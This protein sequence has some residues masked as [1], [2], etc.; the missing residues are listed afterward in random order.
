MQSYLASGLYDLISPDGYISE[1]KKINSA[2]AIATV[3]IKNISPAYKGFCLDVRQIS[4]NLKSTLAQLGLN[5]IG[6]EYLL[7]EKMR[8]AEVKVLLTAYGALAELLLDNLSIGSYIGKLFAADDRR[9]VRDPDYLLR[10][11]N[12]NDRFGRPLLYL[13]DPLNSDNLLLEKKDDH[14]VAFLTLLNGT[15]TYETQTEGFIPTLGK[16]LQGTHF[17]L[18][19][20]LQL[21]QKWNP[22]YLKTAH[23]NE[24]LLVKTQPLHIRTVFGRVCEN[25]LPEGFHHTSAN[26]LEPDTKDSGDVYELFGSSKLELK[27][28]P[29][30]FFTLEPHREHIFFSDRDQLQSSLENKEVL[31]HAFKTTAAPPHHKASTFVV[32]GEQLLQ[33]QPKDWITKEPGFYE[34]PGVIYHAE[35]QSFL[36]QKYI[37][38][39]PAYPFLCAMENGLITSQGVLFSRFLPSP[40][41]KKILLGEQVHNCLKGIYFETPSHSSGDFFSN[42]DR[43]MLHDLAQFAIPVYWADR[44]SNTILQYVPK[45]RTDSGMFTPLSLVDDFLQATSFGIYGSNLL[46]GN[47]ESELLVLFNELEKLRHTVDHPLFNKG[48]PIAV[49]TGGGP[50]VMEIGNKVAKTLNLLSCANIVDFRNKDQSVVREQEQNPYIDI[51]MTY[52]L[53]RLVERQAEFYLDFPIFLKGGIGTDFEYSLEEVRRKVGSIS[54]TPIILFGD[55]DYWRQK[56][57]AKFQCNL[58]SG[59]IAGSEWV[60]NCFYCVQSAKQALKIYTSFFTG[61]LKIGKTGPVFPDGFVYIKE[62]SP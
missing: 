41:M 57:T 14:T 26:I 58:A 53:D 18:R 5:G 42:E 40:L 6:T 15:L 27:T 13:G 3:C 47:L 22:S 62:G 4:F 23:E 52:R 49:I 9:R 43:A 19:P 56:I 55:P 10:M 11:F 54:I 30:E 34:F 17:H 37:E 24:I 25:L 21:L 60:S 59:T 38:K 16:S 35:R 31:F 39:Q 48:T 1:Y 45:P 36:V 7:N 46:S 44:K 2:A 50:G 51:K 20:L 12:R 33:L 32:K 28:I 8:S 29:L 61:N